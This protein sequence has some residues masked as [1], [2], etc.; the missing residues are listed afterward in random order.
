M[1]VA[2]TDISSVE[3]DESL[4][5]PATMKLID[6]WISP[7]SPPAPPPPPPPKPVVVA[8]ALVHVTI[9]IDDDGDDHITMYN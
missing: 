8:V 9:F 7:P 3:E 6:N 5:S 2:R 4:T 1:E